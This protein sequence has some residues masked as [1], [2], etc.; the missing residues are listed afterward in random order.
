MTAS[1]S[2]VLFIIYT[3]LAGLSFGLSLTSITV[4]VSSAVGWELRGSAVASNNFIRTLGQ[5]IG[6]TVFGLLLHTGQADLIEATVLAGSLHTI[7][8]WVAVLSVFVVFVS[9]GMPKIKQPE[10]QQRNA[11]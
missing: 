6:I 1:T 3:F 4:A 7:F 9:I 11:S 5:T 2:I 8:I 10:Q